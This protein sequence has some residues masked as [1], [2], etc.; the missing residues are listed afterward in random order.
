MNNMDALNWLETRADV[1]SPSRGLRLDGVMRGKR[2]GRA[3]R[4]VLDGGIMPL[5]VV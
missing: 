2:S 1:R 5:S 3:A 4:K